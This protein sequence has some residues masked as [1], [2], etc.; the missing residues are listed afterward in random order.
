MEYLIGVNY[1]GSKYGIDMWKYWDEE[2]VE[3]DLKELSK[4]GV[5]CMRVFPNWR[6]FQPVHTLYNGR[7]GLREYRFEDDRKMDNDYGLDVNQ[8]AHFR[9]FCE[10]CGKYGIKLMVAIVTGWMSGRLFAPP[11]VEAENHITSAHSMMWQS[12]FVRGFVNA[13][14]DRPEICAWDLGNECNNLGTA[15]NRSEAFLWSS[16]IRNAILAE[17]HSRPIASGMHGFGVSH[18]TVWRIQDQGELADIL[19]PHPY[20]SPTVGGH[21]DPLN[22]LRTTLVGSAQVELYSGVGK[23]PA[24]IQET[25]TFNNMVGDEKRAADFARANLWSGWAN[26]SVGYL[27][28]CAHDQLHLQN[29][30]NIW[31]MNEN[32]LGILREDY[33]PKQ[34]AHVLKEASEAIANMPFGE[35][36]KR[37][38]DGICVLPLDVDAEP[39]AY[40]VLST[41][42]LAKQAGLDISFCYCDQE[43]PDSDLYIV[44]SIKGWSPLRMDTLRALMEKAK[45]GASVYI[46][47]DNGM[48][49]GSEEYFGL[50]SRGMYDVPESDIM[51]F[52]DEKLPFCYGKKYLLSAAGAEVLIEDSDKTVIFS[53]NR[54]GKGWVYF[55]NF[56]LEAYTAKKAC[57]LTDHAYYK[58]YRFVG[59]EILDRKAAVSKNPNVAVT[60]HPVNEEKFIAVAMNY[61]DREQPCDIRFPENARISVCYGNGKMIPACSAAVFE[62]KRMEKNE[63]A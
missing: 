63:Q 13:L 29:P 17:D 33:S 50:L 41:Y 39:Y 28:W 11:A 10:L 26:G 57:S 37:S 59:K 9:R 49:A 3:K 55:L 31:G 24:M 44:P 20:P 38:T 35:L 14:K 60:V 54:L 15:E 48:V 34:V 43:L 16:M 42:T 12:K 32:E 5:K 62:V 6:D 30:P 27:W 56:P 8:I 53:R 7:G 61:S 1:W 19:T 47:A 23:K 40:T 4:Y 36:P 45:Q 51:E 25:G 58:L 21:I 52:E 22:T 46:S 18:G 2:S